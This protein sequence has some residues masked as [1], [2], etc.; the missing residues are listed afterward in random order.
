MTTTDTDTDTE[1]SVTVADVAVYFLVGL[2]AAVLLRTDSD[3]LDS[4]RERVAT[5]EGKLS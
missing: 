1:Q 2:L 5:L 3:P 4:L